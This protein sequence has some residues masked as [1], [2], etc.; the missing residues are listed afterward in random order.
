MWGDVGDISEMCVCDVWVRAR[1]IVGICEEEYGG[2]PSTSVF[3]AGRAAVAYGR[4]TRLTTKKTGS[5]VA[6]L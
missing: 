3:A 4:A 1:G 6:T 5:R 2:G